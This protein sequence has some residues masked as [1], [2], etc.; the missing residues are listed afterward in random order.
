MI[1]RDG[2]NYTLTDYSI[3]NTEYSVLNTP[4]YNVLKEKEKE[5]TG[6]DPQSSSDNATSLLTEWDARFP[7]TTAGRS[8]Q[9]RLYDQNALQQLLKQGTTADQIR[10]VYAYIEQHDQTQYYWRPYRLLKRIDQG[11]GPTGYQHLT[12]QIAAA[13]RKAQTPTRRRNRGGTP[14]ADMAERVLARRRARRA[15]AHG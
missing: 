9:H 6:S 14:M 12:G 1:G 2:K 7:D 11:R 13:K 8:A 10:A 15:I 3:L 5:S 4:L